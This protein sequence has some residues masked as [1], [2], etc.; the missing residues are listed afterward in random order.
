MNARQETKFSMYLAVQA[1]LD[2]HTIT[3]QGLKAFADGVVEFKQ[4]VAVVNDTARAQ[5]AAGGSGEQKRIARQTLATA[6]SKLGK[7]LLVYAR[8]TGDTSLAR[9]VDQ[10]PSDLLALRDTDC[11]RAA[12]QIVGAARTQL[13]ALADYGCERGARQRGGRSADG[14]RS[15]DFQAAH[16]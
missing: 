3:W 14:L 5:G 16:R 7:A 2:R 9:Q 8:Q 11:A 1:V 10:S 6:A 4:Q 12:A 13:A 15:A